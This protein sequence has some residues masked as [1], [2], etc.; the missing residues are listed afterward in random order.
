MHA[1]GV[2]F[3]RLRD[4]ARLLPQGRA[5]Q[6][7]FPQGGDR[8]ERLPLLRDRKGHFRRGRNPVLRPLPRHAHRNRH[9]AQGSD[10]RDEPLLRLLRRR[11]E[12]TPR[13]HRRRQAAP[14]G[15][16]RLQAVSDRME[17]LRHGSPPE[18]PRRAVGV[19][20]RCGAARPL[21]R[22][23]GDIQELQRL[24]D[25]HRISARRELGLREGP[26]HGTPAHAGRLARRTAV[27]QTPAGMEN[28]DQYADGHY[29]RLRRESLPHGHDLRGAG[30][31]LRLRLSGKRFAAL[32]PAGLLDQSEEH[33]GRRFGAAQRHIPA[34]RHAQRR[35]DDD[36]HPAHRYLRLQPRHQETQSVK[37]CSHCANT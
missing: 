33:G 19:E 9:H 15:P 28:S 5:A 18:R 20:S 27:A 11:G 4:G 24:V 25:G 13:K 21:G 8:M 30:A 14:A 32:L 31:L 2:Q 22:R 7:P 35:P 36:R 12:H 3:R 37:P 16:R 17:H 6:L 10:R 29:V 34:G 26:P 1:H 23:R